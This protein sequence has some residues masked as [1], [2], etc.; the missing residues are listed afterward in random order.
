MRSKLRATLF[1]SYADSVGNIHG[2][3]DAGSAVTTVDLLGAA[4]TDVLGINASCLRYAVFP[5]ASR[6][7]IDD[8]GSI[9]VHDTGLHR[10]FGVAQAQ[11]SDQTLTF[12]SQDGLVRVADLPKASE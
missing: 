11:S 7:V 12:K 5:G 4:D 8:H 10:I 9:S 1:G 3:V 6:L 2:F